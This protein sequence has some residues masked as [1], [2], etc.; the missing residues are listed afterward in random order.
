MYVR[1]EAALFLSIPRPCNCIQAEHLTLHFFLDLKGD[2]IFLLLLSKHV[3][4]I[5]LCEPQ[6][7]ATHM[8]S[9]IYIGLLYCLIVTRHNHEML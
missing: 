4:F 3:T 6:I 2:T 7:R 9:I 5:L 8:Y 1:A